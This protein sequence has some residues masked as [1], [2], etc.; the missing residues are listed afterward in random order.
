MS[1][2]AT[3][4]QLSDTAIGMA[5]RTARI[6]ANLTLKQ[7][8]DQTTLS[9][10]SSLS[11]GENG[12]RSITLSEFVEICSVTG[13]SVDKLI[14]IARSFDQQG[15]HE[16]Q[17]RVQELRTEVGS[18]LSTARTMASKLRDKSTSPKSTK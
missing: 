13:V 12:L 8:A 10:T 6:A 4:L 16:K 3:P 17:Q 5:I 14:T 9:N 7:L 15:V 2:T 18:L 1:N 11:R